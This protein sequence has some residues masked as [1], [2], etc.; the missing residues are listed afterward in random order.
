MSQIP[1]LKKI[2]TSNK[3]NASNALNIEFFGRNVIKIL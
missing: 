2:K 3:N 1:N